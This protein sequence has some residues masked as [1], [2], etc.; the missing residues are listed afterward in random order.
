M[1]YIW[2]RIKKRLP[3]TKVTLWL[4]QTANHF[5]SIIP[6]SQNQIM[7]NATIFWGKDDTSVKDLSHWRNVGRWSNDLAWLNMGKTHYAMINQILS[8]HSPWQEQ[9]YSM[10]SVVE[11]GPGGGANI[12]EL[13]RHFGCVYGVDIAESNLIECAKQVDLLRLDTNFVP[14]LITVNHPEECLSKIN[15]KVHIFLSTAVYQH[16]PSKQYGARMT[17]IA[18]DMLT[19]PGFAI[20]QIRYDD[21]KPYYKP[22]KRNYSKNVV[23][24]TS[25]KSEEFAAICQNSGFDVISTTKIPET[26][27]EYYFLQHK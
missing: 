16:F 3:K 25:Y 10:L 12:V 26:N 17:E 2:E 6:Q 11:L 23:T 1:S 5:I 9:D 20:I 15:E 14:I 4:W 24:F 18:A 7:R 19:R 27:Y 13:C 22:K 8:Q 21:G